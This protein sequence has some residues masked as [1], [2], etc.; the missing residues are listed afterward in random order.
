MFPCCKLWTRRRSKKNIIFRLFENWNLYFA[1]KN[2]E[3][4]RFRLFF[5]NFLNWA[6]LMKTWLFLILPRRNLARWL[7]ASCSCR[8]VGF[9]WWH[10]NLL[11]R[12]AAYC[13][14]QLH[15]HENAEIWP[16]QGNKDPLSVA[17]VFLMINN[18]KGVP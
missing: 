15:M 3:Y 9:F 13:C 11:L 8:C 18:Y 6:N 2:C 14:T 17:K 10:Y 4:W 5:L 1:N 12:D 16:A 7:R